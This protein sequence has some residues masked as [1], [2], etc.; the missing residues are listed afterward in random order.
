V[1]EPSIRLRGK[2]GVPQLVLNDG[3]SMAYSD[4]GSGRPLLLVHGWAASGRFFN[5]QTEVLEKHFRV[6]TPDL[7]GHG[8]SLSPATPPTVDL[9]AAD[10]AELVER[11]GLE[12]AV[13]VGWSMGAMVLW[14]ALPLGLLARLAGMVVVD[15]TPRIVNEDGWSLGLKGGYDKRSAAA[16]RQAMTA[17]WRMFGAAMARSIPAEGLEAERR[18]LIDWVTH[19]VA[20]NTPEP[21]S[22][23]WGSLAE[24]DFR[25]DLAGFELPT[26]IVHGALSQLYAAD[27]SLFLEARLPDARRICFERSGHAP[28][29]EEPELFNRVVTEFAARLPGRDQRTALRSAG[30]ASQP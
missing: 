27:T 16:A 22:H 1:E 30:A 18:P 6:I 23:L 26:L 17:D 25:E 10:L 20:H 12:D 15:M 4:T 14:R 3:L 5:A 19:E 9:L 21:L 11:L 2:R 7:R 29:L 8:A 13:A 24:Q 28:H